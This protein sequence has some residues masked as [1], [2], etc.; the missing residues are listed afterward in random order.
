MPQS[1][2]PKDLIIELDS[3]K[4]ENK[5]Y[6]NIK[7][8]D[9]DDNEFINIDLP[10]TDNKKPKLHNSTIIE[11]KKPQTT[12]DTTNKEEN[13]IILKLRE[14]NEQEKVI[15]SRIILFI[16]KELMGST[17][18]IEKIHIEDIIKLCRNNIG[19]KFLTPNKN[20]K[21]LLKDKKLY[22]RRIV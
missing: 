14:F 13:Q 11:N 17:Q 6:T 20:I 16:T 3:P 10:I 4:K 15:K 2:T 1:A 7:Y 5:T 22:V 9:K 8:L 12:S 18:R 19:N 21:F